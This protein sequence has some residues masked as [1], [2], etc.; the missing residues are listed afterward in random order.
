MTNPDQYG[1][2]LAQKPENLTERQLDDAFLSVKRKIRDAEIS[3]V[4][5]GLYSELRER[6]HKRM[7]RIWSSVAVAACLLMPAALVTVSRHSYERGLEQALDA[8]PE[9]CEYVA[10]AGEIK[11]VLLSDSSVVVLNSGSV[12]ICPSEFGNGKREVYLNGEA[13]FDV[14]HDPAHA[15]VVE[16]SD[17]EIKVHG[18]KFNVSSYSDDGKV[19]AT[20]SRGSISALSKRDGREVLLQPGQRFVID[21][22]LG[23]SSVEQANAEEDLAWE[24]GKLCFRSRSIH[25]IVKILERRYAVRIYLTTG[26]YDSDLI[27][28]KFVQGESL[29]ELMS[30]LCKLIPGM[31]YR[32]DNSNIYIR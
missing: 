16:T 26:K 8:L 23:G 13:S 3:A 19:A 5:E 22:A 24:T 10:G 21:R 25:E 4:S 18:T 6:R 27:T 14:T 28:A 1:R 32:K 2:W 7:V 9:M 12:L 30:A 15:F 11:N 29:D 20:L 31:S 17:M